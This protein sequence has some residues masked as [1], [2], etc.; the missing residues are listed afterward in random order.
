MQN[1]RYV[2]MNFHKFMNFDSKIKRK[3]V[4][5]NSLCIEYFHI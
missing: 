5:G 2:D 1:I 4:S 3:Y